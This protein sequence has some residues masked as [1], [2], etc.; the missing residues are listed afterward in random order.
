MNGRLTSAQWRIWGSRGRRWCLLLWGVLSLSSVSPRTKGAEASGG[1][2]CQRPRLEAA[3]SLAC[4]PSLR[5]SLWSLSVND[6]PAAGGG[7]EGC[8]QERVNLQ[9]LSSAAWRAPK[10]HRLGTWAPTSVGGAET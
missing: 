3:H 1:D 6:H 9:R 5:S 10:A 2:A 8:G 4:R 7:S